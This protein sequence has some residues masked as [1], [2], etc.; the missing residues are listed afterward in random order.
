M[1]A[2]RL[3]LNST[4]VALGGLAG[5]RFRFPK[6]LF[7]G[8]CAGFSRPDAAPSRLVAGCVGRASTATTRRFV[9]GCVGFVQSLLRPPE[10]VLRANDPSLI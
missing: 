4:P 6:G 3:A 8:G 10:R 9:G 7:V 1:E 2:H 5:Y